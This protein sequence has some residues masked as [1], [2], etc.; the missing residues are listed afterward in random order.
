MNFR[1]STL[2][3]IIS[4]PSVDARSTLLHYLVKHIARSTPDS[5]RF[6][7]DLPTVTVASRLDSAAITAEL[8]AIRALLVMQQEYLRSFAPCGPNDRF[9][10]VMT[11]FFA[12]KAPVR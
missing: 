9:V 10:T 12:T 1:L 5:A 11:E 6:Y 4:T 2:S 3:A 7:E 8:T